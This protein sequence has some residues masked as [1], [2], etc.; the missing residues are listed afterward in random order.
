WRDI[1]HQLRLVCQELGFKENQ[2]A[3]DFEAIHRALLAGLLSHVA[4]QDEQREFLAA[5]NRKLR[6]FPGSSLYKKPPKWIVAAEIVE[7]AQPYARCNARI[8][9]QWVLGVNDALLKRHH[10]EPH[11]SGRSG[12]V[13]AL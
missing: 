4:M 12:Q 10:S 11:W 6:V 7:T 1:H 8:D 2:Q 13:M 5:R 9:P 3:A